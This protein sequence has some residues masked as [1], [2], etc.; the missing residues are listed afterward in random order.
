[1]EIKWNKL[2]CLL[3]AAVMIMGCLPTAAL[4]DGAIIREYGTY[5]FTKI[6]NPGA[7]PGEPDGINTNDATGFGANRLN[8]Y[9]WAVASREDGIYIGTNRTLFG[10]ALNALAELLQKQ[11]PNLTPKMLGTVVSLLTGGD[12]PVELSEEGY[13]PQ[14]VKVD[15]RNGTTSVIYQPAVGRDENGVLCYIGA[16]G[17]VIPQADVASEAAS[18]RSVVE[19]NGDLY[20]GTLGANMLQLVRI[21]KDDKAEAVF[22]TVGRINSLRAGCVY[23]DGDGETVYF[24]GMDSTDP[25]WREAYKTDPG[26]LP[27]IIRRLD[28]KTAGTDHED[29]TDLVADFE[30]FGVY[31]KAKVY[32]NGGG[33]VWDLCSFNGKLYLI[34]AYDRGWAMFRGEKGGADPNAYGWTWTE[35]VGDHGAYPLA[36]DEEVGRLNTAFD[37]AYSCSDYDETLNGAGLLESAAT[38][39][40]YNGRMYIGSFDNATL[41][42]SGTVTK[43]LI[44]LQKM[45]E[46]SDLTD[47]GPTLTQIF[48]PIYEALS[49]PQH[50]WVMDADE[51]ITAADGANAL[52]SG[53]TN[54]YVWRFAEHDGKL[55]AG[56]FDSATAFP[57]FL[58]IR[59]DRILAML[60]KSGTE[61]APELQ[62]LMDDSFLERFLALL[63][64]MDGEEN[65]SPAAAALRAAL[66]RVGES[67]KDFLNDGGTTVEA[68]LADMESLKAAWD[69]VPEEERDALIG[70]RAM[71]MVDWLLRTVDIEGLRYWAGA[72]ALL[73]N[74]EGGFDILVTDDGEAWAAV[75]R[76]GLGD[77]YNYGARTFTVFDDELYVGTAN[78]YYGAQLW[79]L[80]DNS[81]RADG[82]LQRFSDLDPVAWYSDDVRFVLES[83]L[84]TGV[85]DG[86]F[87]PDGTTTRAMIV[88]ILYR[89]EGGPEVSGASP[90]DDVDEGRWYTDAIVW[91]HENHIAEGYDNGTFGPDDGITR[92]QFAAILYR[93]AQYKGFDG[94]VGDPDALSFP[95]ASE[96]SDW[97]MPAVRWAGGAGLMLGDEQGRL[98]PGDGA[99]RAQAAALI[100][101]F[102]ETV[103]S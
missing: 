86:R 62:S 74:A 53:T 88:T 71:T 10:S 78:P 35:I 73:R 33:N 95:D 63:G 2:L 42:Q 34:L 77:P 19:F 76:D 21:D 58:D 15:V 6:T 9:A 27:I 97:A 64:D 17:A 5:S 91:A 18:F 3:L 67:L 32:R 40:V 24:G 87:G 81:A 16:D 60:K 52:L 11:H 14:I 12:V 82:P 94:T 55:Y 45:A 28:P 13:I 54:D 83:G 38:P 57:Y 31:A 85:A 49:H 80:T 46:R 101:R 20:F 4:A 66:V 59:M 68:L 102:V 98:L 30:D 25:K 29:W 84:M 23:D 79:K 51:K 47:T 61:F 48:A 26:V 93:Y 50:I 44:K 39:Y 103:R 69:A 8:S 100:R 56:T 96:I 72:R 65:G 43:L 92:E 36:M 99:T 75:V 1:M 22:Q 90:F 70:S 37:D 89:L 41:I 7:G